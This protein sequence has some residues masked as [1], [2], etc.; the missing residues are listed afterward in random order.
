MTALEQTDPE[1]YKLIQCEF[2][3]Q[4]SQ[5]ELIAS[6]NIASQAVMEAQGSVFTNKY[7][8]GYPN[9]RYYGG[10]D[11]ADEAETL[12]MNRALELFDA[13]YANV[14]P[15]SG[16]QANMAVYFATLKP[17]DK[18]LGMDLAHGGHLTHGSSV[19][20]SGQLYN[21]ISYGVE[22]D[23]EMI[24]M[25]Q[26]ARIAF[27]NKPK[28]I[29]AGASAYPRFIDFDAFRKI[30]DE[31]GAYFMV[32]MAHIAGLVAAGVHPSP[33]PYADFV[34]STTHKTLRG[35]R[36]GL[37]LAREKYGKMLDSKIFPGIQG[38]PLVHVIAA[39]AVGFHEAMQSDFRE[40]QQQVVK[41]AAVLADQLN[42]LGFRIVSGGTDNH[43]LLLDLKNKNITGKEAEEILEEAGMTVN[44]N[45]IPF[46][47]ESRFVT[48]G[49]R[50]GTPSVTTRGVKEKEM[51]Q[52]AEWMNRVITKR[53]PESIAIVKEEVTA[54]CDKLPLYPQ[55]MNKA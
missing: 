8:E 34:T 51:K 33:V 21:F 52:I 12:A 13:E 30:A 45:A 55:M 26:V 6:E 53:T 20:F 32:D 35:P 15:H 5:L 3:R 40:Y 27:E 54:L 19:N 29:V 7:A 2:K 22:R 44:K 48:G 39:K 14:Q 47:K 23:T 38:G 10:C 1:I 28:M 9:R 11:Y 31:I 17:G 49:I 18:V 4:T 24:D 41:N 50:I 42:K 25:E 46:D 43:L 16:S 37:I 36:G